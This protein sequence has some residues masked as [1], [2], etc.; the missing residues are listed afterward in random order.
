MSR[1]KRTSGVTALPPKPAV[2][3]PAPAPKEPEEDPALKARLDEMLGDESVAGADPA[4]IRQAI[5][6]KRQMWQNTL[7]VARLDHRVAVQVND[8]NLKKQARDMAKKSLQ[9]IDALDA[10][11][12]VLEAKSKPAAV[13]APSDPDEPVTDVAE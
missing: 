7:E 1:A 13:P 4:V 5:I 3:A 12:A 10:E 2:P 6:Q 11:M 9:A 8:D